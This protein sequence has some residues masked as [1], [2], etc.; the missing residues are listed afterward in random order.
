MEM[1]RHEWW[2]LEYSKNR[3]LKNLSHEDL[4][5]RRNDIIS[6]IT[7]LENNGKIGLVSHETGSIL[8]VMF[9]HLLE[10]F[11]YR[12][13]HYGEGSCEVNIPKPTFPENPRWNKILDTLKLP[14]NG[15]YLV[16][17]GK[18]EYLK[19][20]YENGRLL[21]N[22]ASYYT[23]PSLNRAQ[24]DDELT[25][26]FEVPPP[27]VSIVEVSGRKVEIPQKA[28][29]YQILKSNS[30]FYV[31][32][33][34]AS[35]KLRLFDDFEADCCLFIYSM[36]EFCGQVIRSFT[37]Q[38]NRNK[39]KVGSMPVVYVDPIYPKRIDSSIFFTKHFRYWYQ[40]EYRIVWIPNPSE[41]RLEPVFIDVG[42]VKTHCDLI[43]L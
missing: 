26:T 19:E 18:R 21:I 7:T 34:S 10:E 33:M 11:K 8:M 24:N 2:R 32:C 20:I 15:K 35:L 38:L 27:K 5:K 17:F 4:A 25:V 14:Q 37:Q 28:N 39:W 40:Q 13:V 12:G 36:D 41:E 6:N 23:D 16:K 30:D 9:T 22:P 29:F 42:D 3:Y 43:T 1:R 31:Y